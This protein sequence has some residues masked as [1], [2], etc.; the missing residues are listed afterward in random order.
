MKTINQKYKPQISVIIPTYN[1]ENN[2]KETLIAVKKQICNIP[3]EI[4]VADGQCTE[5]CYSKW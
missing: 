4:I 3:Y 2:I 1:E 5:E